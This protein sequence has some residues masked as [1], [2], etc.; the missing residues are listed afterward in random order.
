MIVVTLICWFRN[1]FKSSGKMGILCW[2]LFIDLFQIFDKFFL[3]S[4]T[5]LM[6]DRSWL[7]NLDTTFLT[8]VFTQLCFCIV[9]DRQET[10]LFDENGSLE[11]DLV[12]LHPWLYFIGHD[13]N[14]FHHFVIHQT[15]PIKLAKL[16]R[17]LFDSRSWYAC[18]R[19]FVSRRAKNIRSRRTFTPSKSTESLT[20]K[21]N[22]LSI[23]AL[24]L[25]IRSLEEHM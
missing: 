3:L 21:Q 2:L 13:R 1:L 15:N 9:T 25:N 10:L 5:R 11:T 6:P 20:Y 8:N 24:L 19:W 4:L 14:C 22:Y 12:N 18:D 16:R 7:T 23:I 17:L